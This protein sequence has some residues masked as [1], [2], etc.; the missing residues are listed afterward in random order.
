MLKAVTHL[1][2]V[3]NT[4]HRTVI[5]LLEDELERWKDPEWKDEQ[6]PKALI[7]YLDDE[8]QYDVGWSQANMKMSECALLCDIANGMFK[9]E[10]NY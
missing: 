9:K 4:G 3:A 7:L 8:G 6:R 1:H 5:Q 2:K 10:M